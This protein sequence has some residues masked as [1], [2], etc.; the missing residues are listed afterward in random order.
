L[1]E[2]SLVQSSSSG[3][4]GGGVMSSAQAKSRIEELKT[5]KD[6]STA[7]MSGDKAKISEMERLTKIACSS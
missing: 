6:W 2:H 5:D 3:S 4:R 1:G 7:Y